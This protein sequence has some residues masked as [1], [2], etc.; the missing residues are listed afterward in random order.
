MAASPRK[1]A[2]RFKLTTMKHL[3]LTYVIDPVMSFGFTSAALTKSGFYNWIGQVAP[4]N[5][6][7]ITNIGSTGI[8]GVVV[9]FLLTRLQKSVDDMSIATRENTAA[10]KDVVN[11]IRKVIK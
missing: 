2:K 10:T 8:L 5:A 1:R 3:A 6:E 9:W 11:E 7:A 4:P